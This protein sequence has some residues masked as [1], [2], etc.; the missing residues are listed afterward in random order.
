MVPMPTIE[1]ATPRRSRGNRSG[2]I[3]VSG[4]CRAFSATWM[5]TQKTVIQTIDE[6][7]P[8]PTRKTAATA[9]P[10]I[11]HGAR[12]PRRERV[13]SLSAPTMGCA[14]SVKTNETVVTIARFDTL[15]ASSIASTWLGS[16]SEMRPEYV[17]KSTNDVRARPGRSRRVAGGLV[18][19]PASGASTADAGAGA[20]R[21]WMRTRALSSLR[22]G[23]HGWDAVR[24][25]CERGASKPNGARE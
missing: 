10:R 15:F 6:S 22:Q 21:G 23:R 2:T 7:E 8:R 19:A 20:G 24:V 12:R 11:I 3:A 1:E 17:A 14:K 9:A 5:T 16:S 25:R 4:P 13:R 18:G